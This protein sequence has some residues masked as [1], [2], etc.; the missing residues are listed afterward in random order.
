MALQVDALALDNG[1]ALHVVILPDRRAAAAP[2]TRWLLQNQLE[3]CLYG[4]AG[5]AA[6]WRAL[7]RLSMQSC[8]LALKRA[9]VPA[10]VTDAEY[11]ALLVLLESTLDLS[12]RGRCRAVTLVPLPVSVALIKAAGRSDHTSRLLAA[13]HEPL[14]RAW[15][16][17]A[18]REALAE[19]RQLDYVLEDELAAEEEWEAPLVAELRHTHVAFEEPEQDKEAVSR[20]YRLDHVPPAVTSALQT[21]KDWR[22]SPLNYQR[23]GN[24]VVDVTAEH[25]A[26]TMLRFLG[27]AKQECN[28]APSLAVLGAARL[29][30]LVQDWLESLRE[31]ALMWSSLANYVN[32]LCNL[33]AY[34][35]ESGGALEEAALRLDPQPPDALLRLRAQCESQA[36]QQQLYAKKPDNWIEWDVAQQGRVK[37]AAAWEKDKAALAHPVKVARLREYLVLLFH[38]VMCA[39]ASRLRL[40]SSVFCVFLFSDAPSLA[41]SLHHAGRRIASASCASSVGTPRSSGTRR[42][43]T[44]WT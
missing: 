43:P 8:P 36:K 34:W 12:A 29:P 37:C 1:V 33:T 7:Q 18:E 17:Q 30:T 28:E 27:F 21:Y 13:L 26:A 41:A 9:S 10:L 2:V 40:K 24:A 39:R 4:G 19:Q 35:W 42:A 5:N 44:A 23:Q 38:T 25:D 31:R 14:P 20:A 22:L 3:C 6:C 16:L 32:S 11:R 15:E